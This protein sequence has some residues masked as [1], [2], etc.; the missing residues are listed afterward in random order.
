VSNSSTPFRGP[1]ELCF[2]LVSALTA[3]K[4]DWLSWSIED[5]S[6]YE[7]RILQ[8]SDQISIRR[9]CSKVEVSID[10]MTGSV[11]RVFSSDV[12]CSNALEVLWGQI[13]TPNAPRI[14]RKSSDEPAHRIQPPNLKDLIESQIKTKS[15]AFNL[16]LRH[17][18]RFETS[19]RLEWDMHLLRND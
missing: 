11:T 10:T 19:P 3:R 9:D 13:R 6:S 8:E 17:L 2:G 4:E 12:P 1:S 16:H 14:E 5:A 18:Y 7:I 15:Y